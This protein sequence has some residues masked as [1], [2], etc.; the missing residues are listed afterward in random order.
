MT[1]TV[2]R[3]MLEI[4]LFSMANEANFA[5]KSRR[6]IGKKCHSKKCA[7][8]LPDV[9]GRPREDTITTRDSGAHSLLPPVVSVLIVT[10]S[11]G[12]RNVLSYTKHMMQN[13]LA[14]RDSPLIP[15]RRSPSLHQLLFSIF[16]QSLFPHFLRR[17]KEVTNAERAE[18]AKAEIARGGN[19]N[20]C[21]RGGGRCGKRRPS[22][23]A[24]RRG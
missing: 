22:R 5:T 3:G 14:F 2:Q 12:A 6:N 15:L 4:R 1:V 7:P 20:Y 8:P 10:L 21:P 23:S 24:A 11:Y 16:P 19:R 9:S 17:T 13:S 18:K